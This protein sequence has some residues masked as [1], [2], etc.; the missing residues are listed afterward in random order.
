MTAN[1]LDTNIQKKLENRTLQP[2]VSAWERLSNELDVQEKKKKKKYFFYIGY[3]A[4]ILMVISLGIFMT[5]NTKQTPIN[6]IITA[7]PIDTNFIR[8]KT[9]FL[10]NNFQLIEKAIVNTKKQ[11]KSTKKLNAF[12]KSATTTLQTDDFKKEMKGLIVETSIKKERNIVVKSEIELKYENLMQQNKSASEKTNKIQINSTDLLY[13]V[14]HSKEEV[15][16]YYAK[17][18]IDRNDVLKN[19]Q[20]ELH[21]TGLK[22]SPTTILAEVE[23]TINEDAFQNNFIKSI[24]KRVKNIATTIASRNN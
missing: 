21:K 18:N 11:R 13:A 1:K 19:I 22:V 5:T 12:T 20:K 10:K 16:Q 15:K 14:T 9:N 2:S 7:K 6:T 23:R 3:A 4:S 17:Y 8:T 24:Q